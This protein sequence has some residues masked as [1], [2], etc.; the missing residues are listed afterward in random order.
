M[1]KKIRCYLFI[2]LFLYT[3]QAHS[4]TQQ[5]F[6][7]WGAIFAN[8]KINSSWSMHF[9]GQARSK[10]NWQGTQSFLIRPGVNYHFSPSMIATIG[11]AYI[12]INRTLGE[13]SGW[14]AEQRIWQQYIYNQGFALRNHTAILQHRLRLEQRFISRSVVDGS[15]LATQGHDF[16][17]RL[18]YFFRGVFPLEKVDVF[19]TGPFLALQNELFVN[20]QNAPNT[21]FFDQNR[22]YVAL[23]WRLA[24]SFDIEGGYMNAFNRGRVV[25]T[26]HNILQVAGYI[27]L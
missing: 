18:R 3:F 10:H 17:Q 20:I 25:N 6:N 14:A 15:R 24:P 1:N 13:T 8:K 23:G 9:D 22:A 4:Q 2:A 12:G 21:K 11:Y 7:G 26:S 19:L 16:S 27:R 5:N